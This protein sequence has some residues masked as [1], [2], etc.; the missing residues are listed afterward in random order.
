[1]EKHTNTLL[2]IQYRTIQ[3]AI[4]RFMSHES[5][6]LDYSSTKLVKYPNHP[7]SIATR[8]AIIALGESPDREMAKSNQIGDLNLGDQRETQ[9][10]PYPSTIPRFC[11]YASSLK[12]LRLVRKNALEI[13]VIITNALRDEDWN[14]MYQNPVTV[15]TEEGEGFRE[16]EVDLSELFRKTGLNDN[17]FF[18][19]YENHFL[20]RAA[21]S[22]RNRGRRDLYEAIIEVLRVKVNKSKMVRVLLKAGYLEKSSNDHAAMHMLWALENFDQEQ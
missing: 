19:E 17:A 2:Q 11:Q 18:F 16:E 6:W 7:S 21:Q 4:V 10:P 15:L 13:I 3:H 20:R 1:M 5:A 8:N 12:S 9:P 14:H 22:F